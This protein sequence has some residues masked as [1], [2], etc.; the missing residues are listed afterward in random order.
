[1]TGTNSTSKGHSSAG[2]PSY[3]YSAETIR[4]ARQRAHMSQDE[5]AAAVG[6]SRRAVHR[7]EAEGLPARSHKRGAVEYVLGLTETP[8]RPAPSRSARPPIEDYTVMEL[9]AAL[10][11]RF[12]ALEAGRVAA[13]APRSS[14]YRWQSADAPSVRRADVGVSAMSS[15]S[16]LA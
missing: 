15:Q 12:A 10:A 2:P 5:L 11:T 6:G 7:W 13:P 4:A 1:M 16:D 3:I 9:L 14:R 8:A